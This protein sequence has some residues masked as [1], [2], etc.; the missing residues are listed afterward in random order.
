[1]LEKNQEVL[2]MRQRAWMY[3]AL[4]LIGGF[5]GGLV[6]SQFTPSFAI[7]ARDAR[8]IKAG[9]FEL[10]DAAGKRRGALQMTSAGMADLVMYDGSG[11]DRAEFRVT[12]D[13]VGTIGF[14]ND[15][16][17]RRVLIGAIPNGR[18]GI[19]IY[20]RDNKLLAGLTVSETNESSLTLYDPNTG[21]AR[22]GLGVA[23]GGLPALALF[24]S[25]GKDRAELHIGANGTAGLAL[26]DESGKSIA[27]L[28]AKAQ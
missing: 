7:A 9:E 15:N 20:G 13:G 24:D 8:T 5:L 4:T 17:D 25:N 10:V 16:G 1:M 28:P 23:A 2:N 14:Y 19:T 6:A 18:N 22:A 21:R 26:A 11:R 27:G 3:A 12:K